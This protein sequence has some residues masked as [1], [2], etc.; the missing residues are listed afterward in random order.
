MQQANG[1]F[2]MFGVSG[3]D[4]PTAISG[5]TDEFQ[6]WKPF[7]ANEFRRV[8]NETEV[9]AIGNT[10]RYINGIGRMIYMTEYINSM[11]MLEKGVRE[12]YS[13]HQVIT[14]IEKTNELMK[15]REASGRAKFTKYYEEEQRL[16]K[17]TDKITEN[18]RQKRL[19]EV[20]RMKIKAVN[21]TNEALKGMKEKKLKF[22]EM[23]TGMSKDGGAATHLSVLAGWLKEY[24]NLVA[25]K[26]ARIDR[27]TEELVRR[28]GYSWYQVIDRQLSSA[29]VGYNVGSATTNVI[30]L[31]NA[32][33]Q[34]NKFSV[35]KGLFDTIR[36]WN[37]SDGMI[38][39]SDFLS[40][41]IIDASF[42]NTMWGKAIDY[43]FV[44]MRLVDKFSS[45]TIFRAKYLE[46]LSQGKTEAEAI[47]QADISAEKI[48][49]DRTATNVPVLFKSKLANI[50]VKFQLEQ[51]NNL[52][53][54]T[55]D[56]FKTDWSKDAGKLGKQLAEKNPATYNVLRATYNL[57]NYFALAFV[58]NLGF[59][60]LL[61]RKPA[62]DLIGLFQDLMKIFGD[63]KE[64]EG[65]KVWKA[66]KKFAEQI[67][68][69]QTLTGGRVPI[70]GALPNV[71]DLVRGKSTLS[72]EIKKPAKLLLP[73]GGGQIAKTVEG[74]ET[75]R[76]EGYYKDTL[77]GEALQYSVKKT[78]AN[79]AKAAVFGRSSLPETNKF[80]EEGERGL[81]AKQTIEQKELGISPE[82]YLTNRSLPSKISKAK[83]RV[84]RNQAK[85]DIVNAYNET[86][87]P[88]LFLPLLDNK[89]N[90]TVKEEKQ[91]VILTDEEYKSYVNDIVD[92][93][94]KLQVR[95]VNV[96]QYEIL[97]EKLNEFVKR[98]NDKIFK[99][100]K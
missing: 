74:I 61:G 88:T 27:I 11:R 29:Y 45:Q 62:F 19:E 90:R 79:M 89:L 2:E 59:M 54:I 80:Y 4:V 47:K 94:K 77:S 82:D 35:A 97:S 86:K 18:A 39:K 95:A 40:K 65:E 100:K 75:V 69:A 28:K 10:I 56:N 43:G 30:P 87:D 60:A 15:D 58:L 85:V 96:R 73:G 63:E 16:L 51:V 84:E 55:V 50:V 44:L 53:N 7:F 12:N 41:R 20:R 48:M 64:T 5:M 98:K 32:L 72:K 37:N 67:P 49:G 68:F 33:S 6:P 78:P 25:G 93:S 26:N 83:T 34:I 36:Y 23:L 42:T 76:R 70:G 22:E 14:E 91:E 57:L 1:L 71:E 8:T 9:D 38:E 46:G 99:S 17:K 13:Q 92:F 81:S 66:V 52:Q 21:E 3:S 24:T 31:V